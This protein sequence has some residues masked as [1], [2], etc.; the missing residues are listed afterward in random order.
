MRLADRVEGRIERSGEHHQWLGATDARGVPVIKV[1]GR[2]T[3][4]RRVVCELAAG[5]ALPDGVRVGGCP[6]DPLCLRADH[7]VVTGAVIPVHD[8]RAR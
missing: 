2:V 8:R 3:T 5:R 6:D 1:D 4:V 7:L